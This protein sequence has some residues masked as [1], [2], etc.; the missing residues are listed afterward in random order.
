LQFIKGLKASSKLFKT[1]LPLTA[2]VPDG[3][4]KLI[5]PVQSTKGYFNTWVVVSPCDP[6]KELAPNWFIKV[7]PVL[8]QLAFIFDLL[9]KWSNSFNCVRLLIVLAFRVS[10]NV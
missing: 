2:L 4:V 6:A 8:S 5:L 1:G 3:A 9:Y 10:T 7:M